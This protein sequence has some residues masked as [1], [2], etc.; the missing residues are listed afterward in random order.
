MNY[1]REFSARE[2]GGSFAL[3][4]AIAVVL[5]SAPLRA[6]DQPAQAT[7]QS[8]T[9]DAGS[10][11]AAGA[12]QASDPTT[13]APGSSAPT[14][15]NLETGLPLRTLMSPIHWGHFS[16]FSASML[17]AYDSN[18]TQSMSPQSAQST[19]FNGLVVYALQHRKTQLDFQ[20]MPTVWAANGNIQ[21]DFTNQAID[22]FTS[23]ALSRHW[24][25]QLHD[26]FRYTPQQ[27]VWMT[28]AFSP[29]FISN[30]ASSNPFL[31]TGQNTLMNVFTAGLDGRLGARNQVSFA[32]T[33]TFIRLTPQQNE[34]PGSIYALGDRESTSAFAA[35]WTR[36]LSRKDSVNASYSF[37]RMYQRTFGQTTEFQTV[38][39]GY[40]HLITPTL[41]LSLEGGPGW[42]TSDRGIAGST[43]STT[44]QGSVA[45][46][47]SFR[48][49]G[50][51]ASF[52]RSNNFVGVI[53]N[54]YNNRYDLSVSRRLFRR[55]QGQLGYGYVQQ[56]LT[57][58]QRLNSGIGYA[59]LAYSLTRNWSV[60][61]SY[62]RLTFAGSQIPYPRRTFMGAG[63]RWSW[64]PRSQGR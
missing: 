29:D 10:I 38:S 52:T 8:G 22:G 53:S 12:S 27:F 46:F 35:T 28:P 62:D 20:Y 14:A 2:I 26:T 56:E 43:T 48:E 45:L 31:L 64:T 3:A 47:K 59:S 51:A 13:G 17:G 63:I 55:L 9:V 60:F 57:T 1:Y 49:G 58:K 33:E 5:A 36:N 18:Y 15:I 32:Y 41:S 6:Q 21:S 37:E 34:T 23:F 7:A 44:A 25:L 4:L 39:L 19:F 16:I 54:N 40:S 61:G 50:I 11:P 30:T 42:A 24:G